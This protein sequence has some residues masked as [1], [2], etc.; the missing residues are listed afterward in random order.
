MDS[1]LNSL[2]I[3]N[4]GYMPCLTFTFGMEEKLDWCWMEWIWVNC[5]FYGEGKVWRTHVII[6]YVENVAKR[7]KTDIV[8]WECNKNWNLESFFAFRGQK[9][10]FTNFSKDKSDLKIHKMDIYSC[11]V[12]KRSYSVVKI[13][14]WSLLI[15]KVDV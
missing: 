9:R 10:A 4:K 14:I 15:A 2:I 13:A 3:I 11:Y 5:Y 12:T 6:L 1:V 8:C 7:V